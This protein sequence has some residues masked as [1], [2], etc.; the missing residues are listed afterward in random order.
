[1]EELRERRLFDPRLPRLDIHL[2][3]TF[4][5]YLLISFL[6]SLVSLELLGNVCM[7]DS[8]KKILGF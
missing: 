5:L 6:P 1:M 8:V 3:F 7:D 4:N 2:Y